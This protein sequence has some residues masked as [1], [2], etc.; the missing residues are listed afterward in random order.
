MKWL[1]VLFG[2]T[3]MAGGCGGWPMSPR[4]T[5]DLKNPTGQVIGRADFW[6][7]N[8]GVRVFVQGTQL[9][10]GLHGIHLHAVGKC[11]PPAFESAAA[12]FNPAAKQHGFGNPAGAHAGDLPNLPVGNDGTGTLHH[13]TTLVTLGSGPNSVFDS[14]GTALVI[15]VSPDDYGT[16]PA[17][18]AGA[19]VACGV[20][21]KAR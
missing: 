12:H 20:V 5:A 11:D 4:A 2:V 7:E 6:E 9:S 8:G 21:T 10:P 16:D 18:N 14:D 19:R 17:G 15:H 3:M 13:L 1:L